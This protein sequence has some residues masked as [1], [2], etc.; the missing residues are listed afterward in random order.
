MHITMLRPTSHKVAH[1]GL[2]V[3]AKERLFDPQLDIFNTKSQC[4]C[5]IALYYKN[6]SDMMLNEVYAL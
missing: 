4:E 2:I 3:T 5:G 6:K 1:A